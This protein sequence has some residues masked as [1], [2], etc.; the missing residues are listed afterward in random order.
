MGNSFGISYINK[1]SGGMHTPRSNI[2]LQ[3][4]IAKVCIHTITKRGYR[5]KGVSMTKKERVSAAI[6]H[7]ETDRVPKGELHIDGGTCKPAP[8]QGISAG[9]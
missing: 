1:S 6:R 4:G 9:L 8:G 7:Q 5:K 2:L 3:G